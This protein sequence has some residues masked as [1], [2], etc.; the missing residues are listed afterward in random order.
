MSLLYSFF[1]FLLMQKRKKHQNVT[2]NENI[3]AE[4]NALLHE[5]TV[6]VLHVFATAVPKDYNRAQMEPAQYKKENKANAQII[7]ERDE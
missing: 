7:R 4:P 1:F 2:K 6:Y 3:F 5:S